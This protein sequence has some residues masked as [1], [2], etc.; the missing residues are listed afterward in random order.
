MKTENKILRTIRDHAVKFTLIEL[1]I[2]IAIIA[3]LAGMMLPALNKAREKAREISCLNTISQL[4][5]YW[6]MYLE[7]YHYV[8]HYNPSPYTWTWSMAFGDFIHPYNKDAKN[9]DL[10][11]W[12][13]GRRGK[14]TCPAWASWR[15]P[16]KMLYVSEIGWAYNSTINADPAA[17]SYNSCSFPYRLLLMS[18]GCFNVL[19]NQIATMSNFFFLHSGK[20]N[21]LYLDGHASARRPG[22]F[23]T[24][25]GLSPFWIPTR[26]GN[27]YHNRTD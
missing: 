25:G 12:K 20:A 10:M 5:K 15:P 13:D 17:N 16:S 9:S 24:N 14:Y 7:Q 2:V 26:P 11:V 27:Y 4:G 8:P 22:T 23:R 19:G 6:V 18:D 21:M 1:L 3:I